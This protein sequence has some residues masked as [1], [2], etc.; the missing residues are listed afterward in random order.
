[1]LT[2]SKQHLIDVD[3]LIFSFFHSRRHVIDGNIALGCSEEP[4]CVCPLDFNVCLITL[5]SHWFDELNSLGKGN[6]LVA[7]AHL[8]NCIY[9][10]FSAA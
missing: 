1:M 8:G 6:M 3:Q 10:G 9:R 7:L 5:S 2:I 4:F